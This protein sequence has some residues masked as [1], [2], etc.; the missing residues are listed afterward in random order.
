MSEFQKNNNG[1]FA[2]SRW[3]LRQH[4]KYWLSELAPA[5][6]RIVH[7]L[8]SGG[9]S[10]LVREDTDIVIE[11]YPCSANS[12]VCSFVKAR[13]GKSIKIADHLHLPINIRFGVQ[14]KKPVLVLVREPKATVISFVAKQIYWSRKRREFYWLSDADMIRRL[15]F[16]IRYYIRF[17]SKVNRI[18]KGF[19]IASFEYVIQDFSK[20]LCAINN[21][22]KMDLDARALNKAEQARIFP[23]SKYDP[24]IEEKRKHYKKYL[25]KLYT[26][27]VSHDLH[28]KALAVY[29]QTMQLQRNISEMT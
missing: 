25:S 16:G 22:F 28:A 8:K 11:G 9:S 23:G 15:R 7:E 13:Q 18:G 17:Y 3:L 26:I 19:L 21:Y 20:V 10:Q 1:K 2:T 14:L 27:A 4:T 24:R 29:K 6:Y 5:L 12:F